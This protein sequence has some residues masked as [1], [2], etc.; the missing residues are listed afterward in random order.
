MLQCMCRNQR[1]TF[2]NLFSFLHIGLRGEIHV[3][4]H[5]G[6][7]SSIISSSLTS[8]LELWFLE[9]VPEC[10]SVDLTNAFLFFFSGKISP[11]RV[12]SPLY[13]VVLSLMLGCLDFLLDCLLSVSCLLLYFL[14]LASACRHLPDG[15]K[16]IA[17]YILQ[18][19]DPNLL[20][21]PVDLKSNFSSFHFQSAYIFGNQFT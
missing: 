20:S 8:H 1:T 3:S 15:H 11:T 19:Y 12:F 7:F 5:Q 2:R 21:G 9:S 6:L 13:Y 18:I 17:A 16:T 14:S 10:V 4:G